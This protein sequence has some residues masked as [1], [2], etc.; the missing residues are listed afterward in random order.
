M[1]L[2]F[3][4]A[5]TTVIAAA[6]VVSDLFL[7]DKSRVSRRVDDEFR[8]KQHDKA[9]RSLLFRDLGR[10]AAELAGERPPLRLQVET[11]LDQSGLE[12]SVERLATIA[13]GAAL[14]LG[15]LGALLRQSLLA[16]AAGV[17][18]G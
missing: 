2:T 1:L 9:E 17:A 3:L 11:W 8:R 15:A 6:S 7:R 5:V 14:A 13:A 18:V 4:A 16:A 10:I 12:L